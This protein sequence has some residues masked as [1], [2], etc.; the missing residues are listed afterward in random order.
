MSTCR[1]ARNDDSK[2]VALGQVLRTQGLRGVVANIS[3][4]LPPKR[5]HTCREDRIGNARG[6]SLNEK[7]TPICPFFATVTCATA[8]MLQMLPI[9]R[10]REHHVDLPTD[11]ILWARSLVRCAKREQDKSTI[12]NFCGSKG[13]SAA[14]PV[15][16]HK[17]Y[18]KT[19]LCVV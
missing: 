4:L 8:E 16:T 10:N 1:M 9:P 12:G 14:C 15:A 7:R 11:E 3:A 19:R 18:E 13:N 17:N 6:L 2:A 5:P